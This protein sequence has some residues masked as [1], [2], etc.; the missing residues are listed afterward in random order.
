MGLIDGAELLPSYRSTL[1][2]NRLLLQLSGCNDS[3]ILIVNQ[4]KV[5]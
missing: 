3:E 2:H 1:L 5:V 4:F